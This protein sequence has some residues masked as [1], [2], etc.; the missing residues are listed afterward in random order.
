[1]YKNNISGVAA[2]EFAIIAPVMILILFGII[3]YGI[4]FGAANSVQQLA[5]N[6]ARAAMGGISRSERQALVDDYVENFLTHDG[7][8]LREHLAVQVDQEEDDERFV[9]V[10]VSYEANHLPVWNLYQG[11]PMPERTIV[12]ESII[13]TG[14][15]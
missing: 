1:M 8:L 3:A 10:T 11:L 13:R 5:A 9:R 6:S 2:I 4:F 15:F 14:G 7:L 12:R